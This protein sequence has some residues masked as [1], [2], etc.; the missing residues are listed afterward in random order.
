VRNGRTSFFR[1]ATN[2]SYW[3]WYGFPCV[4]TAAYMFTQIV[5]FLC[6]G[7]VAALVLRKSAPPAA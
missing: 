5:G 2:V 4:Y 3:N 1:I 7:I 6:I